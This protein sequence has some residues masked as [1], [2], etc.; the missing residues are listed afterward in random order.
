MPWNVPGWAAFTPVADGKPLLLNCAADAIDCRGHT[1][2]VR[3]HDP[4]QPN[5]MHTVR[6][7]RGP[8]GV[9]LGEYRRPPDVAAFALSPDGRLLALQ[10]GTFQ[11][12]VRDAL[13]GGP[14][15][16]VTAVGRYHHDASVEVGDH[17]LTIQMPR[18][19]HQVRWEKG[20]LE[21][22]HVRDRGVSPQGTEAR[23]VALPT[24][25]A[26][27][28]RRFRKL[29]PNRLLAVVDA[30]GQVALFEPGG[31]LV[32]MFFAFRGQFAAWMPDGT[33]FG[34]EALLGTTA[35]PGAAE[36][37]GRALLDA[38]NRSGE[39]TVA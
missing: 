2:A 36:R 28:P 3:S 13:A 14:P 30:Y 39:A 22:T 24:A 20:R 1:L 31:R 7:F 29:A 23:P 5:A 19:L 27:D 33:C 25:V 15:R 37:I 4:N 26:Y 21:W 11:V 34:S 16:C 38:W 6:V 8:T 32:C 9:P 17:R 35:T 10:S 12:E 18:M